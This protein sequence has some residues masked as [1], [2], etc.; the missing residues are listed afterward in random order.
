MHPGV[1]SSAFRRLPQQCRPRQE[2][3]KTRITRKVGKDDACV[4]P[5]QTSRWLPQPHV[6]GAFSPK[7][8]STVWSPGPMA[9]SHPPRISPTFCRRRRRTAPLACASSFCALARPPLQA[10]S[11]SKWIECFGPCRRTAAQPHM[12]CGNLFPPSGLHRP[13]TLQFAT[14]PISQLRSAISDTSCPRARNRNR[15][16]I[17]LCSLCSL[18]F[19]PFFVFMLASIDTQFRR[20]TGAREAHRARTPSPS[21][22][23]SIRG[24]VLHGPTRLRFE[25]LRARASP[26][27]ARSASKW[28]AR[29]GRLVSG[30]SRTHLLA[31]RA[32]TRCRVLHT[33]TQRQQVDRAF[34]APRFRSLTDPLAC[35]SS[36]YALPRL[37]YKHAAPASGSGVSGAS[38]PVLNGPTRLRFELVRAAASPYKHA[39]PASGSRVPICH[40]LSICDLSRLSVFH[41]CFICGF[42]SNHRGPSLRFSSRLRALASLR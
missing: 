8:L 3:R 20:R 27:Q 31:L 11:A 36:S 33:S 40:R 35:A 22:P 18:L 15:L 1:R 5:V 17:S 38:F 19:I 41:P 34:R 14:F 21:R 29:F 10:R 23:C 28:I 39:A 32:R 16:C 12:E 26:L 30:P 13:Q 24:W 42:S 2:P 37:P 6:P 4:L 25:L 7:A 9:T